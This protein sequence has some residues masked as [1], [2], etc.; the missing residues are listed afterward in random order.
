MGQVTR[1]IVVA[2]SRAGA[3]PTPFAAAALPGLQFDRR[4]LLAPQVV[5]EALDAL[6]VTGPPSSPSV[7]RAA[8]EARQ[9]RLDKVAD[10]LSA[11][12]KPSADL[13]FLRGLG[14][15]ARGEM[16]GA[17]D[18]FRASLRLRPDFGPA[19]IYLGAASA[20][21][22]RDQDAV[23]AWNTAMLEDARSPVLS[24]LMGDALL[25]RGEID[26]AIDLLKEANSAWPT[27]ERF[28]QR[29]GLAY[30]ASGR[31]TEALPL[32]TAYADAHSADTDTLFAVVR[33]LY[34]TRAAPGAD[35]ARF[36]RYARAYVAAAGPQ[37]ALVGQWIKSVESAPAR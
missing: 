15:Y 6:A 14:L 9:G 23:G 11:G 37:Q 17:A 32:L 5:V 20:A 21:M 12:E 19:T 26:S 3:A 36:L 34:E 35:R 30:L 25:R 27:D 8:D 31:T 16:A 24:L 18:Q 1:P 7:S 10:L 2:P 4:A 28:R 33:L 29:L 22:G 13:A